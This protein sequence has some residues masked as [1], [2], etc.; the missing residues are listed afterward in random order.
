MAQEQTAVSERLGQLTKNKAYRSRLAANQ[1]LLQVASRRPATVVVRFGESS[2]HRLSWHLL[3]GHGLDIKQHLASQKL[4]RV[5][6]RNT[7]AVSKTM[8]LLTQH[9][10]SMRSSLGMGCKREAILAL[11]IAR[12]VGECAILTAHQQILVHAGTRSSL[13]HAVVNE[14]SLQSLG[15]KKI[16]HI[17]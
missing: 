15:T 16:A 1:S 10:A 4:A 17:T 6:F 12:C 11:G 8:S 14:R 9:A 2:L 7:F 13:V 3:V 5:V